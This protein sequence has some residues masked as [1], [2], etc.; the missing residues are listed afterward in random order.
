MEVYY[1]MC[2]IVPFIDHILIVVSIPQLAK[3]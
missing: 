2:S 3:R 1:N